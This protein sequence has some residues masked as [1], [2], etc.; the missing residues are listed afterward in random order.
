MK[1]IT[2]T[3]NTIPATMDTH[4]A[5]LKTLGVWCCG[6]GGGATTVEVGAAEV[7]DVSLM[8]R[9]MPKETI[10]AAMDYLCSSYEPCPDR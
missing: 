2:E 4:A 5:A 9:M 1:K 7:S 10:V 6:S 8:T 3:M